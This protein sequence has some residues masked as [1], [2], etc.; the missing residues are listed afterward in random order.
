MR[1]TP[2]STRPQQG[3]RRTT[4]DGWA[5]AADD[6]LRVD[7]RSVLV[8][9]LAA[10][11]AFGGFAQVGSPAIPQLRGGDVLTP[12]D[13]ARLRG[14][15]LTNPGAQ[16]S[17]IFGA[18]A[19]SVVYIYGKLKARGGK[20]A[21]ASTGTGS[22]ISQDGLV[23]TNHHVIAEAE[24]LYVALYPP[25]GRRALTPED[26][27]Q[28]R[29]LRFDEGRDLALIRFIEPPA[30][31]RPMPFGSFDQLKVGEEVHAIGHPLGNSWTYTKG[32]VSQIREQYQWQDTTGYK[33]GASVIQTQTPISPGNSGGPLIDA[34][35]RM[36]GVNSFGFA[37]NN[38]QGLNFAVAV[39]EVENFL[40]SQGN[41]TA[42][43]VQPDKPAAENCSGDEPK[44]LRKYR[45]ST[46]DH[47]F[48]DLDVDCD[49]VADITMRVPDR[50]DL[51]V[52]YT[53]DR[54]GKTVA[55][56]VD[57]K[58]GNRIDYSLHDTDGDGV[59]DRIGVHPDGNFKPTSF[60]PYNGEASVAAVLQRQPP[61]R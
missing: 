30:G 6:P 42:Q 7:R 3:A 24:A 23:I 29:L 1:H 16:G 58:R 38:A 55:V 56:L 49:G 59:P 21:G 32:V 60:V 48:L 13:W 17:E 57:L 11:P 35:G 20:P 47:T 4:P 41:R 39:N 46:N 31:L 37:G 52:R 27:H 18:L 53:I 33:R 8:G 61:R 36:I 2:E 43:R 40:R 14:G 25:G 19:P 44:V 51:A 54:D 45:N 10:L 5:D 28:A 22:I 50:P 12:E 26:L 34:N 9:L 15:A